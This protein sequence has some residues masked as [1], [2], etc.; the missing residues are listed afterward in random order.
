LTQATR[1]SGGELKRGI[2][3]GGQ[4]RIQERDLCISHDR[5]PYIDL[6]KTGQSRLWSVTGL[7]AQ[8]HGATHTEEIVGKTDFDFIDRKT[9]LAA[10]STTRRTGAYPLS[11]ESLVQ[12][13]EPVVDQKDRRG[14]PPTQKCLSR[15]VEGEIVGLVG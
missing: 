12:R 6:F 11:G 2:R 8:I 1:P 10:Q 3:R 14:S 4:A 7:C 5:Q 15:I 13:E 9:V